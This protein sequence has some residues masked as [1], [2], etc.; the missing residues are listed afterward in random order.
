M[1]KVRYLCAHLIY[2]YISTFC[3]ELVCVISL[4]VLFLLPLCSYFGDFTKCKEAYAW[5]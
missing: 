2:E 5:V 1:L 3:N 4:L